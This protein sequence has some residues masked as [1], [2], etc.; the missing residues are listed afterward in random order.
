MP[1]ELMITPHGRAT[2]DPSSQP[3]NEPPDPLTKRVTAAFAMGDAHG[4]LHL[5]TTE[6][7]SHL[8]PGLAFGRN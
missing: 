2:V 8:P 3:N 6:L 4:L 5:A 1:V 7:T